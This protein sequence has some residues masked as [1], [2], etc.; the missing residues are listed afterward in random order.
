MPPGPSV[1]MTDTIVAFAEPL[2]TALEPKTK[3][4]GLDLFGQVIEIWNMWV[5]SAPPW[6]DS[7][8]LDEVSD[9]IAQGEL[10]PAELYIHRVLAE[11]WVSKFRDDGRLVVDWSVTVEN[12]VPVFRCAG[13]AATPELLVAFKGTPS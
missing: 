12:G 4:Q 11:R 1:D 6:N 9:A 13:C 7:R 3:E 10:S 5:A 2:L 8:G